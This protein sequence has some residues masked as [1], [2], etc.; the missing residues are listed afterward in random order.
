MRRA[1][2]A[3]ATLAALWAG[4]AA[5]AQ[6]AAPNDAA[7][8]DALGAAARAARA[9]GDFP[10]AERSAADALAIRPDDVGML[11]MLATLRAFDR[12]YGEAL[13][14][15]A[16]AR[17]L[18]PDDLDVRLTE[19]RILAWS[20][21]FAA[22]GAAAEAVLAR[23]PANAE[24][25]ALMARIAFYRGDLPTARRRFADLLARRP[26][27][28]EAATGLA[29]VAAAEGRTAEA[30]TLY[31]RAAT[32][33]PGSTEIAGRLARL[34]AP[35]TTPWRLDT[36]IVASRFDRADRDPWR[37]GYAVLSRTLS[38]ATTLSA[39]VEQSRRFRSWDTTLQGGIVQRLGT[40][41]TGRL[42]VGMT[43]DPDFRERWSLS[44]GFDIRAL[45]GSPG[46]G[47]TDLTLDGRTARYGNRSVA[48]I[49]PGVVQALFGGTV[50]ATARWIN[51]VDEGQRLG[52]WSARLDWQATERLR[53][54]GGLSQ[55]P[56]TSAGTTVET[57]SWQAGLAF[58]LTDRIAVRLDYAHEDRRDVW[59][60]HV[61]ATGLTLRF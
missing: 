21:D 7:R 37:E 17:R 5:V 52:G 14:T 34:D 46:A 29:D 6:V 55:A 26:D 47:P 11:A 28:G 13:A 41:V 50:V 10:A 32:L 45:D 49:T 58:D 8:F 51:V 16:T 42:G 48:T 43:P 33:Q 59:I 3:A 54:H 53:V 31:G 22:A 1:A 27:D 23:D 25:E 56:E 36:G 2:I 4:T 20:G 61:L 35:S 38:P 39:G 9:A 15:I 60:R 57:A 24:A 19:G 40:G 12:R 30:R 18:A 44:G